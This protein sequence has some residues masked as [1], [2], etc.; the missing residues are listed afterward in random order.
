[1]AKEKV[2]NKHEHF[3]CQE[4]AEEVQTGKGRCSEF[5]AKFV[6]IMEDSKKRDE[7]MLTIFWILYQLQINEMH[8][9]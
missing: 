8:Q 9:S 1:M 3:G 7:D 6:Q 2:R 5:T 4:T